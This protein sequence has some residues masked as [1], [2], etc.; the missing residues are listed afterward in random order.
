[1]KNKALVPVI[2][3]LLIL[4]VGGFIYFQ[5]KS[6]PPVS[7]EIKKAQQEVMANCKY[8]PDFCKYAANGIVA[9]SGG[10]TMTSE[11][12]YEGKKSKMVMKADGKENMESTTF[13]D[14][15]EEG[16]FITLNKITYMKGPNEK[17]WTEF[18]P[19]KDETGKP[20]A[21]LFDFE[22]LKKELGDV[23][24]EVA[25]T[26]VVKK[27]G[28][29]ACGKLTCTVF[30]MTEKV[31]NSTTK[32]WVDTREYRARKMETTSKM[33]VSTMTFEYGPVTITAPS[34]VKKMPAFD[35]TLKDAG[36]NINM[37]EIKKMMKDIPQANTE[38]A[39]VE[40]PAE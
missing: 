32:I 4:G 29:E 13:T 24:K 22:G 2:G 10:Y 7:P 40:T 31:T 8:D 39:P 11:S 33:G 27:V 3:I 37:D 15:K 12:S 30:E 20:T 23:T 35:S 17:E 9:M 16:S 25:D 28:T 38:E 34:P 18:P 1:M 19:S 26:L 14:G 6:S 21:N 36:V 5:Q